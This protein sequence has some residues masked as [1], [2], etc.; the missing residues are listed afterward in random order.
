[1]KSFGYLERKHDGQIDLKSKIDQLLE[2]IINNFNAS[3]PGKQT[4]EDLQAL[5]NL[6]KESNSLQDD[7]GKLIFDDKGPY[8]KKEKI[9]SND[10]SELS[11]LLNYY[12]SLKVN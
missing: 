7:F 9:S 10:P 6:I 11:E 5:Q 2:G 1:M 8:A 12:N 3:K 4:L